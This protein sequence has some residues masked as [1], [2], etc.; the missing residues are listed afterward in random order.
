MYEKYKQQV[1]TKFNLWKLGATTNEFISE[2]KDDSFKTIR[3]SE[4]PKFCW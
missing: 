3:C 1:P 4:F 2:L